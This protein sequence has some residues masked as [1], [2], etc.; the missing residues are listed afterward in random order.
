MYD[1][2]PRL[3]PVTKVTSSQVLP[4]SQNRSSLTLVVQNPGYAHKLPL[5]A[6]QLDHEC[7]T[8]QI[9]WD[10]ILYA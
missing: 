6:Y 8:V 1:D 7:G 5:V 2:P 9:F 10:I 4:W 3:L